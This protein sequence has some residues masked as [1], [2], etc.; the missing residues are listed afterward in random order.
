MTLSGP[1]RRC[2]AVLVSLLLVDLG[3]GRGHRHHAVLVDQQE[4]GLG[5]VQLQ[6]TPTHTHTHKQTDGQREMDDIN[7]RNT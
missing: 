4:E 5:G 3:D 1:R 7:F 2:C 6:P